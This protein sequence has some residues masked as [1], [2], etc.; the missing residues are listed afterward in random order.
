M[1]DDA[2]NRVIAPPG[3]TTLRTTKGDGTPKSRGRAFMMWTK[4]YMEQSKTS[5]PKQQPVSFCPLPS[6]ELLLGHLSPSSTHFGIALLG[7]QLLLSSPALPVLSK[8]CGGTRSYPKPKHCPGQRATAWR[9]PE[10][11]RGGAEF[12]PSRRG[13]AE[14]NVP[15]LSHTSHGGGSV[16]TRIQILWET[17]ISQHLASRRC[18]Q[19]QLFH[20]EGR[21]DLLIYLHIFS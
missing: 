13:S 12:S 21:R 6:T 16:T 8:S 20:Q 17:R 11:P 19:W 2:S 4:V 15:H 1:L 10:S 3:Q 5:R 9:G 18:K 7:S 14:V